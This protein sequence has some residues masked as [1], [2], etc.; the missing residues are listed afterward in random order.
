MVGRTSRVLVPAP[1]EFRWMAEGDESPWFPG[2]RVYRQTAD[3]AWD[4]ALAALKRDL[5]AAFA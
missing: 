4:G 3:R 2:S 5:A 1:P